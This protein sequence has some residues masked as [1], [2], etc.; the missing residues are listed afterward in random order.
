MTKVHAY[1]RVSSEGQ[2]DGDGFHRQKESIEEFCRRHDLEVAAW[3]REEGVSGAKETRPGLD[4]LVE[5]RP[6]VIIVER[7][8][9]LARELFVQEKIIRELTQRGIR[10][11][12]A[13]QATAENVADINLDPARVAI[14][15]MLGVFGQLDKALIVLKLR[16][17]REREREANGRCEGR[18]R[19]A[20][21][22]PYEKKVLAQLLEM[23]A[24]GIKPVYMQLGL[25][26]MGLINRHTQEPYSVN[27]LRKIL[28]RHT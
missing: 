21:V 25:A 6:E 27:Y 1:L 3:I 11:F 7:L 15:Q 5:E 20:E 23:K 2:V 26:A 28:R 8:D 18:K 17:A 9:R 10:L 14:R 19:F 16:K 24:A 22:D 13:D 4:A 12:S